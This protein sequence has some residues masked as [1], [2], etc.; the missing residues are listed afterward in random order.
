MVKYT[1][2]R[3]VLAFVT[4]FII[5]TVTFF[6]VKLQ[7]FEKPVATTESAVYAF[8][9]NQVKLGYLLDLREETAGYGELLWKFTDSAKVTHYFYE[10][11]YAEQYGVWLKGLVTQFNWGTSTFISPNV[12]AM[13]VIGERL[14][15]TIMV[16]IWP[17]IIS[18]PVG[19]ALGIWAALKKN[20]LTDHIIST[21]VMVFISVPSFIVI[22]LMMYWLCYQNQILPSQWPSKTAPALERFQGYIIP[23]MALSFGSICGYCRFTRAELTEVMSSDFLLLA[24]T[25]GLTRSQAIVRHALKNA[26]VPILPSILAEVISLLG[27]AMILEQLY[28]IPGV[29]KLYVT[30]LNRKDYNV[31]MA[32]MGFYTL[33]GLVSGV[34]LDLSY[35]FIDPRIRMGARK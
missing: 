34:F 35:G 14:P 9:Q 15:T 10:R 30:A 18:V 8:Y 33:I 20:K 2:Q 21:L 28:G 11:S 12:D 6:L 22:T 5:L 24:R 25:K 31:L 13:V 16:N 1:I 17:V 19:I 4:A 27:G 3:L 23:T 7:P 32:D 29:G 26:F